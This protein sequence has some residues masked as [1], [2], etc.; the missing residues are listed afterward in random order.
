MSL[1]SDDAKRVASLGSWGEVKQ[2]FPKAAMLMDYLTKHYPDDYQKFANIKMVQYIFMDTEH[3]NA[4]L[5]ENLDKI[6]IFNGFTKWG[7]LK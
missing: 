1:T 4:Q 6:A 2:E 7:P 3:S 5:E